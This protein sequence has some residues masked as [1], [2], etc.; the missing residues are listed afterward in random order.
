MKK[1]I[2]S[3]LDG[4]LVEDKAF[5]LSK[6]NLSQQEPDQGRPLVIVGYCQSCSSPIYGPKEVGKQEEIIVRRSCL[7]TTTVETRC[8]KDGMQTK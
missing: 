2:K 4:V 3:I 1:E 5:P 6:R 8:F 7:C